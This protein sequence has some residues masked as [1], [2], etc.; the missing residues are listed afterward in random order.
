MSEKHAFA[1]KD[2][3]AV[4]GVRKNPFP[5]DESDDFFFSTPSL[6]KQIEGL[7][8][9]VDYGELVLVVSGLEGAGKTTFLKQFVQHADARW[10]CCRIDARSD[11]TQETLIDEMLA[12]FALMSHGEDR[13]ADEELLR[14]HLA[15]LHANDN[16][17]V[18]AVDDAHLLPYICIEWLLGLAEERELFE[19]RV[20][21]STEPG[22]LG[23]PTNDAKRVH[24]VAL[25]PFDLQQ[26]GDYI[27]TRLSEAGLG[28]DSPF[29]T[30]AIAGIH[31]DSGGL[32][33][34]IHSLALHTL[35]AHTD[36]SRLS[37]QSLKIPRPM[38]YVAAALVVAVGAAALLRPG[39]EPAPTASVDSELDAKARGRIADETTAPIKDAGMEPS[40]NPASAG[41][42]QPQ[43]FAGSIN[44]APDTATPGKVTVQTGNEAKVFALDKNKI[45]TRP[46][47]AVASPAPIKGQ[48]PKVSEADVRL[49]S[50][51]TTSVS[52]PIP[53]PVPHG[54]DWLRKQNPSDY[55]I[56]LVGTR[57]ASAATKFLNDHNL[58]D[59]GAW[60][61]TDHENKPWYV[62]VYG[63]YP[64]NA[65]ARAAIKALPEPLRAG[66]PWPRSVASVVESA[67]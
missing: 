26:S 20:L 10:T 4:Y 41:T 27:H 50:N 44:V 60:F 21:L 24:V 43:A 66:S 53:S 58:G 32:P 29:N 18:V 36:I 8:N 35:L 55:V 17:A 67:R 64:D 19:L 3:L 45:V 1:L 65:S 30:D 47:A 54:L 22:R 42:A 13:R 15:N 2:T 34:T 5:I 39:P 40:S 62:V 9:L 25:Q 33:G 23:F 37:R 51:T 61:A 46:A 28:G 52:T 57:N 14:A 31:Q 56:Q 48:T 12:G 16:I 6:A 63:I 38:L 59:K 7:R 11:M 49:A